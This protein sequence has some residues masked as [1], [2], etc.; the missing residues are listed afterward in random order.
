LIILVV[1]GTK[2]LTYFVLYALTALHR[3]TV[4]VV[5]LSRSAAIYIHVKISLKLL[6]HGLHHTTKTVKIKMLLL[7]WQHIAPTCS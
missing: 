1:Y 7:L 4:E 3:L 5:F 6:W 2:K